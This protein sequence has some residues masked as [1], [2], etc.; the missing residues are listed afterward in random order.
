[1]NFHRNPPY[2][3]KPSNLSVSCSESLLDAIIGDVCKFG[4]SIVLTGDACLVGLSCRQTDGYSFSTH[5]EVAFITAKTLSPSFRFIL[6]AEL[7]V[8]I[9]V[10]APTAVRIM[11]SDTTLSDTIFSILPGKRFRM[12][13][14]IFYCASC[15]GLLEA[16]ACRSTTC[17]ESLASVTIRN[18]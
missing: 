12:L 3:T 11:T 15:S 17:D 9:D 2:Q 8:I 1:M 13:V 6:F 16:L 4:D 18:R 5:T 14:L 7:V 10:T